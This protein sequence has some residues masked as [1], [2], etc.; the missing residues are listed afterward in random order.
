[1]KNV[2]IFYE[3]ALTRSDLNGFRFIGIIIYRKT[4]YVNL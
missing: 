3:L 1:M 4:L 2:N